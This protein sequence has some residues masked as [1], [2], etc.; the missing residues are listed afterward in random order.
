VLVALI[1]P[2]RAVSWRC[3]AVSGGG[4]DVP[5]GVASTVITVE[6]AATPCSSTART[7][8]ESPGAVG[9]GVSTC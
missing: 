5:A 8:A 6:H 7:S 9:L 1:A 4:V 3:R 2:R